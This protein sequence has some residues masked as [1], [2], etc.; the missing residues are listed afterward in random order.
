MINSE[1]L[2]IFAQSLKSTLLYLLIKDMNLR[3]ITIGRSANCDIYLDQNCQYASNLHGTIYYDGFQL[4]Y[5][6]SSRNGTM[7]NNLRVHQRAVPINRGDSILIAGQYPLS[8]NVID[9][10]FPPTQQPSPTP[11]ST[12]MQRP[13]PAS[14]AQPLRMPNLSKWSWGA[15]FLGGIWGVFNGCWWILLVN[16]LLGLSSLLPIVGIGI[17]FLSFGFAIYCGVKGT[18]WAWNNKAWNSVQDF[19]STQNTWD[20]VSIGLFIVSIILSILFCVIFFAGML[21]FLGNL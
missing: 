8:W 1:K 19:E 17:P 20:K 5:R 7:V 11:P 6:D 9:S 12:P 4:M 10:Y 16:I 2:L 3:E 18:E 15:F 21:S 13:A 14:Y